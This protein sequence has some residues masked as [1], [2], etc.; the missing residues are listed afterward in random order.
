M[1]NR[2]RETAD[3]IEGREKTKD[4]SLL[5]LSKI[6]WNKNNYSCTTITTYWVPAIGQ[7]MGK[8]PFLYIISSYWIPVNGLRYKYDCFYFVDK[9]LR[10]LIYNYT[11]SNSHKS[12]G[13]KYYCPY[14]Q[15]RKLRHKRTSCF[16]LLSC[17][18]VCLLPSW[19]AY[20]IQSWLWMWIAS[21][22]GQE[23]PGP[24]SAQSLQMHL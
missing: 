15:I 5:I 20:N 11:S 6:L 12:L 9:R 24:A 16:L 18:A 4:S 21:S 7:A 3:L 13:D 2:G 22:E 19:E 23:Q 14:F 10:A 8:V 1:N 17:K